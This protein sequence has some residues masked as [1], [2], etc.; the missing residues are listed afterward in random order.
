MS[1][2]TDGSLS[3]PDDIKITI[4]ESLTKGAS[5]L[6][7]TMDVSRMS[8]YGS[9]FNVTTNS[10]DGYA[11]GSYTGLSISE[12]GGI[13]ATYSNDQ[14]QL[15]GIVAV[16]T[17]PN[18]GALADAGDTSWR[19]TM[20]SGDAI[21]GK[22]GVGGAGA[23]KSKSLESSNVDSTAELVDMVVAQSNYQANAKSISA[24]NQMT[25]VLMNAV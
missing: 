6:E 11:S 5:K 15:Q 20:E 18:Q 12:D 17:F 19:A 7:V 16:A 22:P 10:Q 2:N 1:F 9:D 3:S 25:Q 23:L 13:Y 21:L 14:T 4:P 8:Q 24:S